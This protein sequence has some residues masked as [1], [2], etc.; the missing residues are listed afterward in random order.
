MR[1]QHA[2]RQKIDS[3]FC[4]RLYAVVA[5]IPAGKVCTYGKIASLAGYSGMHRAAGRAM[6]C[7]PEYLNLPCHRVVNQ[8]GTLAPPYVF[9]ASN[10]R[11]L[12]AAEGITFRPDGRIHMKKHLWP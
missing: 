9:G 3:F 5:E 10:Q 1:S 11:A 12:L 2:E 7:V 4:E 6:G 8:R